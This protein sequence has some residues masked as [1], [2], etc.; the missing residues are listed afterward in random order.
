MRLQRDSVINDVICA[1]KFI[2]RDKVTVDERDQF[3]RQKQRAVNVL[4]KHWRPD[5]SEDEAEMSDENKCFREIV[6]LET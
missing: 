4:N 1:E 2:T 6:S 3:H 5:Y